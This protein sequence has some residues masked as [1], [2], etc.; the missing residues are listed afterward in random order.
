MKTEMEVQQEKIMNLLELV[1]ANPDL[2]II[3]MVDSE[4]GNPDYSYTTCKW[5]AARVDEYY[6]EDERIYFRSIDMDELV[7]DA[8]NDMFDPGDGV[9]D[10]EMERQA[11]AVIDAYEWKKAIVVM[12]DPR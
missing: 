3:P 1:K 2:E 9:G 6:I 4:V 5:G 8:I 11:A 12:I 10:E 7:E